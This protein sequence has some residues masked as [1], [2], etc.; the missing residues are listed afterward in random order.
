MKIRNYEQG[1][2]ERYSVCLPMCRDSNKTATPHER[3]SPSTRSADTSPPSA[4]CGDA[5]GPAFSPVGLASLP[6]PLLA[7]VALVLAAAAAAKAQS[8][9]DALHAFHAA[10]R[11]LDGGPPG[12]LSQWDARPGAPPC[13]GDTARWD[14]VRRCAGG[15]VVVLQLEGLRL[16]DA[17][18]DLRL[19]VPLGGLRLL[20]LANNSLAGGHGRA[21]CDRRRAS[22][23]RASRRPDPVRGG[24]GADAAAAEARWGRRQ[25]VRPG[26]ESA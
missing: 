1:G 7:A 4:S 17:A 6:P 2:D 16:Q 26:L 24:A 15:R 10:L 12:E 19:L 20:S 25:G 9:A 13:D 3:P 5:Q 14:R 21:R 8:E 22:Q 23:L 18:P 11:G